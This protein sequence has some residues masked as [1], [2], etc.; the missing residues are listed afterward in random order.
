MAKADRNRIES[1]EKLQF[2]HIVGSSLPPRAQNLHVSGIDFYFDSGKHIGMR[3]FAVTTG[4]KQEAFYLE[5][6]DASLLEWYQRE[7]STE[8][9]VPR[10]I[11]PIDFLTMWREAGF[12]DLIRGP[13]KLVFYRKSIAAQSE[14]IQGITAVEIASLRSP[15]QIVVLRASDD[16]PTD[17]EIGDTRKEVQRLLCDLLPFTPGI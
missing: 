12:A 1:L 3:C 15:Q 11:K 4:Y 14:N 6:T 17:I 8:P 2:E 16:F 10:I 5:L 9:K 13:R 7:V